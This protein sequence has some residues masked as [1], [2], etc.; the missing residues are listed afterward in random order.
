MLNSREG[1]RM[2]IRF[3][4]AVITAGAVAGC[5]GIQSAL[6]PHGPHAVLLA[7]LIWTF[8]AICVVVWIVVVAVLLYAILRRQDPRSDPLA[9]D[10]AS[11]RRAGG[12]IAICAALT[13]ITVMALTIVSYLAQRKLFAKDTSAVE[14]KV[15]G[16]QWWWEV[17]YQDPRPDRTFTTA[18]EIHVPIGAPITIKLASSDVIHSFWV[19]SLAGKMD[20]IPGQQNE[21]QFT[22]SRPGVYRGQCAEFCGLQHAHMGMLIVATNQEEFDAWRDSQIKP[23]ESPSDPDTQK[24]RQVFLSRSCMMCHTIRGTPAG[25]RVGPDLTHVSSRRYLAAGTLA[26][27]RGNLAAWIYDP[28]GIKP[29]ANMPHTELDADELDALAGYLTVLK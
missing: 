9:T 25:S 8:T 18:N 19:P 22:V 14:I 10:P 17:E 21:L 6:D 12:V 5:S 15:T 16:H 29:G 13:A 27:S 24:G 3:L 23:A 2:I 11:E 4:L 20:L 28:Q 7:R 26:L 1:L